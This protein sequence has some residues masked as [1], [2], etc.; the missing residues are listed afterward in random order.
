MRESTNEP[1]DSAT[2]SNALNPE[3][4]FRGE[5]LLPYASLIDNPVPVFVNRARESFELRM[6]AHDFIEICLVAEGSGY[7]YLDTDQMAVARGDLFFIPIGISHVFRPSA[8]GQPL[9]LYNCIITAE[10]LDKLLLAVQAEPELA[11]FFQERRT[12]KAWF[13]IHDRGEEA[14]RLF[15]RLHG[16]FSS[17]RPGFI[18]ALCALTAELL[19]L[20]Y[21]RCSEE[22]EQPIEAD[23]DGFAASSMQELLAY[24]DTNCAEELRAADMAAKLGIGERQ[25]QRSFKKAAGVTFLDYVQSARIDLSCRLLLGTADRISDIAARSG[26]LNAKFFNRLF[27]KKTG[28]TPRQYRTSAALSRRSAP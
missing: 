8:K 26:Y 6:H 28:V 9:A 14:Q 21:R 17:R 23:A 18:A 15:H 22:V 7:H 25:F 12:G 19:V 16:E 3:P 27:K 24:I 11:A 2:P 20:L 5:R 4:S 10:Q 13:R 1:M